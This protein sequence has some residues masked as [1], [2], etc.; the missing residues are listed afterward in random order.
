[1][2]IA[3]GDSLPHATFQVART[4]GV[5]S[6]TTEEVF[7]GR[8]VVLVGVPGAFTPACDLTHLPGFVE[9][10]DR[11]RSTGVDAIAVTSVNDAFVL[12]AWGAASGAD[13]KVEFL[14]DGNGDF[15]TALGLAVD[16]SARGMGTRSRRYAMVVDD[17]VVKNLSIDEPGKV[18]VS[19]AG[20]LLELLAA[21]PSG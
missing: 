21:A 6:R 3:I 17:L 9:A 13:G 7:R 16:A 19:S 14:A 12:R 8:R 4:E 11:I 5:E 20:K 2:T 18:D 15:A 1:M 10:A